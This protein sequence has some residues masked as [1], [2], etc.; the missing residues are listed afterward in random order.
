M[1]KVN[2]ISLIIIFVLTINFSKVY[3]Q[4]IS[5]LNEIKD[6][7]LVQSERLY[8]LDNDEDK[9]KL[10][11]EISKNIL[12]AIK[13]EKSIEFSFDSIKYISVLTSE[14][15]MLR[16][17]SWVLPKD[18]GTYEC[19]GYIQSY[20]DVL[21]MYRQ[22]ELKDV[23]KGIQKAETKIMSAEKWF[24]AVYYYMI[25]TKSNGKK[26]YTVL[27]WNPTDRFS[28]RK[29]IE[30]ITLK[31]NGEPV[32]GYSLFNAKE[33][34][35]VKETNGKRLI[36]EY[37]AQARMHLNYETQMINEIIPA[38]KSKSKK[39]NN[40]GGFA[41]QKK[42][43]REEPETKSFTSKLIIFDRLAPKT[44]EVEGIY[45]FYFPESNIMDGLVFKDGK[46]KFYTEIDARNPVKV[47]TNPR[48]PINYNLY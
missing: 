16:V 23:S 11:T 29:V 43:V 3:S 28:R 34:K 38:K 2:L 1:K 24:G 4:N 13:Q 19:F 20:D 47:E 42:D 33:L 37:S 7:L 32:F 45:Q 30:I 10:N 27:G 8:M 9:L 46:W 12:K 40:T 14:D 21:K 15:K 44:K 48:K 18:D 25:T 6:S 41:S 22:W 26:Y 31:R 5:L 36:F 17:F 35:Y 39:A